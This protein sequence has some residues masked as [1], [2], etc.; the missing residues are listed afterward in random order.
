M[1]REWDSGKLIRLVRV[2]DGVETEVPEGKW[3]W[4]ESQTQLSV[5]RVNIPKQDAQPNTPANEA[6]PR[7]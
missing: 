6:P 4:Y 7:R 2:T 1:I 3:K 5:A